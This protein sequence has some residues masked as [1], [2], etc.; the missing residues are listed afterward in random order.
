MGLC[1]TGCWHQHLTGFDSDAEGEITVN[2]HEEIYARSYEHDV[3]ELKWFALR[4]R[5]PRDTHI[6]FNV[7]G[8]IRFSSERMLQSL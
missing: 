5:F 2:I 7:E 6:E 4:S 1:I 8:D 3:E